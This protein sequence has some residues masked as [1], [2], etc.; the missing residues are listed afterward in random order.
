MKTTHIV[1]VLTLLLGA[2]PAWAG[3]SYTVWS[4]SFESGL[5]NWSLVNPSGDLTTMAQVLQAYTSYQGTIVPCDGLRM[6][7]IY[8]QNSGLA[9]LISSPIPV[10]ASGQLFEVDV[11]VG[12]LGEMD[13]CGFR[14]NKWGYSADGGAT[15]TWVGDNFR[16]V[17][18]LQC[19]IGYE[20]TATG[21]AVNVLLGLDRACRDGL[22]HSAFFDHVEVTSNTPEPATLALLGLGVAGLVARR[23]RK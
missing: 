12:G 9:Y 4:D 14:W 10:T 18:P 6:A 23:C 20:F 2:A 1:A 3:L 15:L 8:K 17:N 5:G 11:C 22:G 19:N 7:Q 21:S 13:N 16:N